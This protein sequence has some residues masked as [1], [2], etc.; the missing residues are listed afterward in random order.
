MKYSKLAL[1]VALS[2]AISGC[3]IERIN[4]NADAVSKVEK[5]LSKELDDFKNAPTV[6]YHDTPWINKTPFKPAK[7]E[8][9]SPQLKCRV[10]YKPN[11]SVDVYQFAQDLAAM[12]HLPVRVSPDV[13]IAVGGGSGGAGTRQLSDV[14]PPVVDS[15]RMIP[16]Q[17]LSGS[18]SANMSMQNGSGMTIS[19]IVYEGAAKGLLDIVTSRLGVYWE[20]EDSGAVK[21][22]YLKTAKF[23]I[24]TTDA[25]NKLYSMV[26]S[27]IS[28]QAGTDSNSGGGVTGDG[29]TNSTTEYKLD[30]NLY[31]DIKKTAESMLT[32]NLGR[33]SMNNSSGV[34]MVTDV[35]DV[36]QAVGE[37]IDSENAS[38]SKQVRLVAKLYSL[39][40]TNSD[41]LD[42]DWNL[43]WKSLS[44]NYGINLV[45]STPNSSSGIISGGFEVL[46]TATGRAAQFAGSDVL[47]KAL[48]E[49]AKV[50]S[51]KT[52]T[53]FTTNL[54]AVP[55]QI[56]SQVAYLQNVTTDQTSNVGSSQSL[57]PGSV[58]TGTNMTLLPKINDDGSQMYL[59]MFMDIS[60][61]KE[62][63][64]ISSP[65]KNT[66]IE[67][68]NVDANAITQ[69][70]WLKPN[71]TIILSGFQ[72]EETDA[73][74]QG[75]G[76][77]NNII[78]GGSQRGKKMKKMFVIT[79]TA[80]F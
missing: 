19:D 6:I 12:C 37:Y 8:I 47:V 79:L 62:L 60:S 70:V 54:A 34:V 18:S 2:F 74:K 46:D 61:L 16:L 1:L 22:F 14:P 49:Q 72:Q 33:L 7:K 9:V 56:A 66:L 64:A 32:P 76:S 21:I 52:N 28:T 15:S 4:Q 43:V 75:V 57:N 50:S 11:G 26:K 27:G 41:E 77:P 20:V 51:V 29:G 59:T 5:K 36:V 31:S 25:N 23:K 78:F 3:A 10:Q 44:G 53:I 67:A 55:L 24:D 73:I 42:L 13:S 45:N 80:V 38:L 30:N 58:T 35:P 71:Q 17:S 63:R 40:I 48:S 68:P 39:D 69:R 65:D